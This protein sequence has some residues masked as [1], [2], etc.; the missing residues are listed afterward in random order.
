MTGCLR[1]FAGSC[2]P[3]P[4]VCPTWSHSTFHCSAVKVEPPKPPMRTRSKAKELGQK[5]HFMHKKSLMLK[6]PFLYTK[7]PDGCTIHDMCIIIVILILSYIKLQ[8]TGSTICPSSVSLSSWLHETSPF[9]MNRPL[10][11]FIL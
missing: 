7:G 11:R 10:G 1:V 3:G 5:E 4:S 2:V 6:I 8:K 9:S